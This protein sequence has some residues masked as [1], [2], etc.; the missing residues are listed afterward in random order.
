[1]GAFSLVRCP[2]AFPSVVATFQ[3]S[4][5][6]RR[7]RPVLGGSEQSR[8]T[9]SISTLCSAET[10]RAWCPSRRCQTSRLGI[11]GRAGRAPG[12]GACGMG[13]HGSGAIPRCASRTRARGQRYL[14][15]RVA[16]RA[17][18]GVG[19]SRGG[20]LPQPSEMTRRGDAVRG[21][22]LGTPIG[23]RRGVQ[24]PAHSAP[25]RGTNG[26]QVVVETDPGLRI[27]GSASV[28]DDQRCR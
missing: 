16:K 11:C 22:G 10:S 13:Y 1:M 12:T 17:A 24:T 6:A 28:R 7:A 3:G 26:R 27:I 5:H 18:G 25:V 20:D 15:C 4:R 8:T 23:L 9:A 14:H 19:R 21:S 2:P